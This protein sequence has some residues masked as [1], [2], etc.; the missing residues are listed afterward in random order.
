M[1]EIYTSVIQ[2]SY[3]SIILLKHDYQMIHVAAVYY[4]GYD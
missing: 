3:A 4:Y 2:H 1:Q